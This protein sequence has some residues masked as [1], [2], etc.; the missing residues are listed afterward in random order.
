MRAR[1]AEAGEDTVL[2]R[3][4]VSDTGAGIA[5]EARAR[6]FQSFLKRIARPHASTA[7]LDSG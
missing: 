7:V 3:F 5:P 2:V 6:L 4:E 1:L